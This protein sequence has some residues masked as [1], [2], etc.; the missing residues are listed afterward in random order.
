MADYKI[1]PSQMVSASG[2]ASKYKYRLYHSGSGKQWLVADIPNAGDEVYM[3]GGPNSQGFGGATLAFEL[4]GGGEI[5]LK[6]PWHS[7]SHA[8]WEAIGIDVRDKHLTFVVI[9]RGRRYENGQAILTDVIYKDEEPVI[10]S[11]DRG[12]ELARRLGHYIRRNLYLYSKSSGGSSCG[13]IAHD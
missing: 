8:L 5:K 7:S 6:G 3:E 11:F 4:L 13:P 2:E 9:S 12:K 1:E 10:G